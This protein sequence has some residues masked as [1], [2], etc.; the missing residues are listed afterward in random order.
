MKIFID[1]LLLPPAVTCIHPIDSYII[2]FDSGDSKNFEN[3][4]VFTAV[5][6][7]YINGKIKLQQ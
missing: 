5:S 3:K 4:N 1:T 7:Q 6:V 2:I